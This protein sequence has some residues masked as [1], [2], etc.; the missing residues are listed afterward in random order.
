MVVES[1]QCVLRQ[2]GE[3][4]VTLSRRCSWTAAPVPSCRRGVNVLVTAK[5]GLKAWSATANIEFADIVQQ[6]HQDY[7]RVGA[8]IITCNNFWTAPTR[9]E[10]CGLGG[11]WRRYAR[12]AA[13]NALNVRRGQ[14]RSYPCALITKRRPR[15]RSFN[16]A[17]TERFR[18]ESACLPR[19][20]RR[21]SP[22]QRPISMVPCGA[23]EKGTVPYS[24]VLDLRKSS[25]T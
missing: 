20:G 3:G 12:A 21:N 6:V 2:G 1:D 22:I 19:T 16:T 5:D 7:L 14:S 24:R 10:R 11:E 23:G 25:L 8:D 4:T 13:E 17:L 15:R 9:L 18:M